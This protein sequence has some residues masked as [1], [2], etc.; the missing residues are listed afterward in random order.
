M[1]ANAKLLANVR[2]S[3]AVGELKT[4]LE[5]LTGTEADALRVVLVDGDPPTQT[6]LEIETRTLEE[7]GVGR[8]SKLMWQAQDPADA[9]QRRDDREAERLRVLAA[10]EAERVR[11]AKAKHEAEIRQA[12]RWPCLMVLGA[13]VS[14]AGW[15]SLYGDLGLWGGVIGGALV[16]VGFLGFDRCV[17]GHSAGWDAGD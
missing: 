1:F 9:K 14:Q 15:W 4:K 13:A 8:G 17:V 11:A 10:A 6:N 7:Y 12:T 16:L 2:T 3:D 5:S